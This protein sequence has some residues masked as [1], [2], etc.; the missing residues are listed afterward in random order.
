MFQILEDTIFVAR[1]DAMN[2]KNMMTM[3]AV[4]RYPVS[5]TSQV[6]NNTY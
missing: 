6:R 3:A 2:I 1:A 5:R 4:S